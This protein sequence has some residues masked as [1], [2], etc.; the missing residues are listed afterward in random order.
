MQMRVA[1]I[2]IRKQGVVNGE[3][4]HWR[5]EFKATEWSTHS[6]SFRHWGVGSNYLFL[7]NKVVNTDTKE[8]VLP[9]V[10]CNFQMRNIQ[11]RRKAT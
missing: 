8:K 9:Q 11:T 2:Q 7:Q 5:Y 4:S 1:Q 10:S 6:L 3:W